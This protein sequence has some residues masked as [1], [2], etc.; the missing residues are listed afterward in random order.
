[1]NTLTCPQVVEQIELYAAG[2]CD[3]PERTAIQ[4]HLASC[5]ACA[6]AE[7]EARQ[8]AGLLD[9][10]FQEPDRLE[11]LQRRIESEGRWRPRSVLPLVR[12]LAAAAAVVALAVGLSFWFRS[13]SPEGGASEGPLVASLLPERRIAVLPEVKVEKFPALTKGT[14]RLGAQEQ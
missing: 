7:R 10:R 11:R 6:R 9:I 8:L 13:F 2:E 1:M 14:P 4:R 12:R 5:S 3:E